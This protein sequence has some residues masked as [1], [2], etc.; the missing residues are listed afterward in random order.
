MTVLNHNN[1]EHNRYKK[2]LQ[3][4]IYQQYDNYHIVFVDD[5]S[6]DGSM[7]FARQYLKGEGFP[8]RMVV[9]VQNLRRNYATYNIIN[10]AFNFCNEDDIQVV[11]DGDD[12][13]IGREAFRVINQEY[14]RDPELWVVY[15]NYKTNF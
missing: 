12:E 15:S 2:L 8:D 7:S 11:V 4:I 14:I 10:A 3:S 13:I 9:F 1:V 5:N 6:T